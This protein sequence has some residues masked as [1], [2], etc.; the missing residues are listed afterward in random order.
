MALDRDVP[1]ARAAIARH[2]LAAGYGDWGGLQQLLLAGSEIITNAICHGAGRRVLRLWILDGAVTCEV[3]D[4]GGG[5]GDPLVGYR[6]PD[7]AA[8]GGRGLWLARQVCDGLAIDTDGTGT[9]V[10]FCIAGPDRPHSVRQ[11]GVAAG[12]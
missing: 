5:P 6:P 8:S 11:D 4:E 2:M 7:L 12:D 10:R 3:A 1:A 9:R